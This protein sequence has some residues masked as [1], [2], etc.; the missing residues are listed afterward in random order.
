MES[1]TDKSFEQ[2]YREYLTECNELKKT[3]NQNNHAINK[4][5]FEYETGYVN[6]YIDAEEEQ[7]YKKR[8]KFE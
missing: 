7:L 2:E 8:R 3:V 5:S 4:L 1:N 6:Q